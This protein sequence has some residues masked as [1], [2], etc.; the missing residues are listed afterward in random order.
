MSANLK[1]VCGG[2]KVAGAPGARGMST[3]DLKKFIQEDAPAFVQDHFTRLQ[4]KDRASLCKLLNTFPAGRNL[5]KSSRSPDKPKANANNS[6]SGSNNSASNRGN[7]SNSEKDGVNYGELEN[8]FGNVSRTSYSRPSRKQDKDPLGGK[9]RL[10][11]GENARLKARLRRMKTNG[12]LPSFGT[13]ENLL[14]FMFLKR[15][16][17]VSKSAKPCMTCSD[18]TSPNM[19][20]FEGSGSNATARI[21]TR[22]N[23]LKRKMAKIVKKRKTASKGSLKPSFSMFNFTAPAPRNVVRSVTAKKNEAKKN[24]TK[25][26][27][28]AGE[29]IAKRLTGGTYVRT[30][31]NRAK[32]ARN[33]KNA[34]ELQKRRQKRE[35]SPSKSANNLAN[36]LKELKVSS[37]SKSA[38]NLTNAIT[39]L[40]VSSSPNKKRA[41]PGNVSPNTMAKIMAQLATLK[42]VNERGPRGS[43][44]T[45]AATAGGRLTSIKNLMKR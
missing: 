11:R 12:T 7:N 10:Q 5:L 27:P 16:Q 6:N 9:M 8:M 37:P 40:K 20:K 35:R 14:K 17:N 19:L 36:A 34:R 30:N 28:R 13:R 42:P 23:V 44:G 32:E 26:T 21:P 18:K 1:R 4:K 2:R 29:R 41:R 39:K 24:G 15:P 38:N 25:Y 3:D 31:E 22:P 33:R 43:S 45:Y